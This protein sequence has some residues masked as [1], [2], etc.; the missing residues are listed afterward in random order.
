[1]K[2]ITDD[3][4]TVRVNFDFSMLDS[5][6][7][8]KPPAHHLA[9]FKAFAD[10]PFLIFA[11][12]KAFFLRKGCQQSQNEL[13]IRAKAVNIAFLEIYIDAEAFQH[14]HAFQHRDGVSGETRKRLC[15]NTVDLA[16]LAVGEHS[17]KLR[18]AV[19]CSRQGL[20]NIN[21]G[22]L[23]CRILLDVLAVVVY[24][25]GKGVK[26]R[27]LSTRHPRIGSDSFPLGNRGYGFVFRNRY[28]HS[29]TSLWCDII[30]LKFGQ[31]KSKSR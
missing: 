26:H 27:V 31:I 7:Q 3:F 21:T 23:P 5:I 14:P 17:L 24:L 1:M 28:G 30:A 19:L 20:I 13:T 6:S 9:L 16:R 29:A 25:R 18:A 12:R 8:H 22:I 2:N 10:T 15:E 11:D 4:S